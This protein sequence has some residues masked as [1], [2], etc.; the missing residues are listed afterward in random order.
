MKCLFPRSDSIS[1]SVAFEAITYSATWMGRKMI[2]LSAPVRLCTPHFTNELSDERLSFKL[3][4][5]FLEILCGIEDCYN[6]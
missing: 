5:M 6:G 3:E 1:K 4:V 2:W